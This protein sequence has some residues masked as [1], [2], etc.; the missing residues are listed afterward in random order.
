VRN[1]SVTFFFSALLLVFRETI[2]GRMTGHD[3]Y[4]FPSCGLAS[5]SP[6][7]VPQLLAFGE[8]SH[9]SVWRVESDHGASHLSICRQGTR[10][11]PS[12]HRG[13]HPVLR[14]IPPLFQFLAGAYLVLNAIGWPAPPGL[15]RL[16]WR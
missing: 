15:R 14:G 2:G 6:L 5:S 16:P 8:M 10:A 3:S 11:A 7:A 12:G 13:V 4:F 1:R 9:T